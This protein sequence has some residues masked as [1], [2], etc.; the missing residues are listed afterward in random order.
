MAYNIKGEVQV[1]RGLGLPQMTTVQ[2]TAYT[3]PRA[4]Y[5]VYDTDL[6]IDHYWDGTVWKTYG[7]EHHVYQDLDLVTDQVWDDEKGTHAKMSLL[8]APTS[9]NMPEI[10]NPR[11]GERYFL[12]VEST[13]EANLLFPTGSKYFAIDGINH[14]EPVT[15]Y[16][17]T[18]VYMEF[19]CIDVDG[20]TGEG[21]F[22]YLTRTS[23]ARHEEID[24]TTDT[25]RVQGARTVGDLTLNIDA[26]NTEPTVTIQSDGTW[27]SNAYATGA[28]VYSIRINNKR[29][30]DVEIVFDDNSFTMMDFT[31]IPSITLP[32][33][34]NKFFNFV[35]RRKDA[36]YIPDPADAGNGILTYEMES[37]ILGGLSTD[38]DPKEGNLTFSLGT[39]AIFRA[40]ASDAY[41]AKTTRSSA[42]SA[43]GSTSVTNADLTPTGAYRRLVQILNDDNEYAIKAPVT[44]LGTPGEIFEISVQND[45]ATDK[46][47]NFDIPYIR[48]D[49]TSFPASE[50]V[51]A[52]S[53]KI[54]HFLIEEASLFREVSRSPNSG[55]VNFSTLS[56]GA[57]FGTD[58]DPKEG[59][60]MRSEG[61]GGMYLHSG[62]G[63]ELKGRKSAH[64]ATA[65]SKVT[66]ANVGPS[67]DESYRYELTVDDGAP[68]VI[69]APNANFGE[70]GEII[71]I[72]VINDNNVA[73]TPTF[74]NRYIKLDGTP[75]QGDTIPANTTR[76]YHFIHND[77][78]NTW[79]E[80][81]RQA[82]DQVNF[83]TFSENF[84]FS[85]DADPEEG[86]LMI[87]RAGGGI[88]LYNE[89]TGE[90]DLK[91]RHS[92][93]SATLPLINTNVNNLVPNGLR[94]H[95]YRV[96]NSNGSATNID[97][98]N[99]DF[100]QNGEI[101]EFIMENDDTDV[102]EPTFAPEYVDQTGAPMSVSVPA[103]SVK[104]LHFI[105]E[106]DTW[107]EVTNVTPAGA[108]VVNALGAA[109]MYNSTPIANSSHDIA[110]PL[111]LAL[112]TGAVL[113]GT[114]ISTDVATG[115]MTVN[116][117]S[118]Y[119][120]YWKW[121]AASHN[122]DVISQV[123]VNDVVVKQ[124]LHIDTLDADTAAGINVSEMTELELTN[125][126]EVKILMLSNRN[127]G[128]IEYPHSGNAITHYMYMEE[129]PV[130]TIIDT[131]TT[132]VTS[133]PLAGSLTVDTTGIYHGVE[134]NLNDGDII[135]L[136]G[137][138]YTN[139]NY[140]ILLTADTGNTVM[141]VSARAAQTFAVR[142]VD[143]NGNSTSATINWMT[144][145][146]KA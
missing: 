64:N 27:S 31:T 82:Y 132:D 24:I 54:Y 142:I 47:V 14:P 70:T 63:Y 89:G 71:E 130:T 57:G 123:L 4:G 39:G 66:N 58:P 112:D 68:H 104:V 61:S 12:R 74:S 135:T 9:S 128:T 38:P 53:T 95:S 21:T 116:K 10:V 50:F 97:K 34:N 81:T 126:D 124:F 96:V 107:R 133:L 69:T 118:V 103:S 18:P 78:A 108:V 43:I 110:N 62:S 6:E 119:H 20:T 109:E 11:L 1:E 5:K 32:G 45:N 23:V 30:T 40:D 22:V 115:T 8:D 140:T 48:H 2:R 13:D 91:T 127:Q 72:V 129:I 77:D 134:I 55:I 51:A 144:L 86:H 42:H 36:F 139:T 44:S 93:H 120:L 46:L 102:F 37:E 73:F 106:G 141:N 29:A 98:P 136:P 84:G 114:S 49:G 35:I 122:D 90:W 52:N 94:A 65:V 145:G 125:G 92:A 121:A 3:P 25:H 67:A 76:V 75:M 16:P 33:L 101:I 83:S 17:E 99:D 143:L 137:T 88:W 100:V 111:P 26:A 7:E 138:G 146:Q 79:R 15:V 41:S 87:S 59:N 19:R 113:R 117:D 56:E 80:I 28:R 60:T 131:A 85:P 105:H